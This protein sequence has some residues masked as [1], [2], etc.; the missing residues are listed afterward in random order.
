MIHDDTDQQPR[1]TTQPEP[2]AE[3]TPAPVPASGDDPIL[4]LHQEYGIDGPRIRMRST[5]HPEELFITGL[6]LICPNCAARRDWMIICDG[7][8]IDIRC[9]CAHQWH[10]PELS[11]ADFEAMIDVVPGPVYPSLEDAARATGYDGTFTGMYL[12]EPRPME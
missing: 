2:A 10:E 3:P 5:N 6:V 8:R 11:R 1:T 7:N 4:Q 9:R 12:N